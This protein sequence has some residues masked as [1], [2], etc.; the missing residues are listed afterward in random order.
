MT[1]FTK[2]QIPPEVDT[3][4]KLVVWSAMM[5]NQLYRTQTAIE[6]DGQPQ[7]VAQ[8]GPYFVTNDNTTRALLRV[9]VQLDNN[10]GSSGNKLWEEVQD[11]G[12]ADIPAD[13]LP[14]V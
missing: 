13:F 7:R 6:G 8:F 1:A 9:S 11:L 12:I 3:I 2:A 4:E 10:Y 14:S 5:L